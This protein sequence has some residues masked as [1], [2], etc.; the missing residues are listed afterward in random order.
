MGK[1]N[2][3]CQGG[4]YSLHVVGAK[5][6]PAAFDYRLNPGPRTGSPGRSLVI[7][8]PATTAL[9]LTSTCSMPSE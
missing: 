5:L 4:R 1:L 8:P 2:T 6:R 3:F 7:F 9:P